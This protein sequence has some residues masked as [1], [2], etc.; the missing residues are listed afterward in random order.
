MQLIFETGYNSRVGYYFPVDKVFYKDFATD[1][2]DNHLY[3]SMTYLISIPRPATSVAT[4]I[5]LVPSLRLFNANSLKQN[6]K[7][8][9]V[10][11]FSLTDQ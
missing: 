10:N 1:N 2:R 9:S 4:N 11:S 8:N 5:S 6:K 7:W 3:K